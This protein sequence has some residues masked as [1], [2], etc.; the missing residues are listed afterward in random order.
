[1]FLIVFHSLNTVHYFQESLHYGEENHVA[2]MC[3]E[4][5]HVSSTENRISTLQPKALQ[6]LTKV[7]TFDMFTL[8]LMSRWNFI[9]INL[10]IVCASLSRIKCSLSICNPTNVVL[11]GHVHYSTNE[12]QTMHGKPMMT[13]CYRVSMD[14]LIKS[15]VC[16]PKGYKK[17]SR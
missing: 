2:S 4:P 16:I 13:D 14:E 15:S 8:I 11:K 7:R 9:L 10:L 1:M 17:K 3:E 5:Q 12:N 6:Q